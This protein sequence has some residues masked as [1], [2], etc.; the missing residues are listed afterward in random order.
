MTISIGRVFQE[1]KATHLLTH[2]LESAEEIFQRPDLLVNFIDNH[3]GARFLTKADRASF[4]QA[5]LFIMTIP[6]VP[7][8][9]YGTEQELLGMR[10][11]MFK[12]GVGSSNKDHFDTTRQSFRFVQDL[13]NLRKENAVLRRGKIDILKDSKVGPGIFIYKL[14]SEGEEILVLMN[15]ANV[16]ML[17]DNVPTGFSAGT[18]LKALFSLKEDLQSIQVNT[19]GAI[20]LVLPA[21]AGLVLARDGIGMTPKPKAASIQ[22]TSAGGILERGLTE[23][24][25]EGAATDLENIQIVVDGNLTHAV[26]AEVDAMGHWSGTISLK[27]K[28]NGAHQISAFARADDQLNYITDQMMIEINHLQK[29]LVNYSDA[30]GD[31][32]GPNGTYQYPTHA[33]YGQ[34]MDI[35]KVEIYAIGANLQVEMTMHEISQI[36]IPPNG[37]DHLLVNIFIDLPELEGRQMLPRLNASMPGE[38]DWDFLISA[39]GFGNAMFS[40]LG[41]TK[42]DMGEKVGPTA[43]ISVDK[44]ENTIRFLISAQSMGWIED[45]TGVKLYITTW[46]GGPGNPRGLQEKPSTWAFSGGLS[47]DPKIMDA[48]ELIIL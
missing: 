20:N 10:Q 9:Y 27:D 5:L 38:E 17:V 23:L 42:D 4:R 34:N 18:N 46:G 8:I 19:H 43:G 13:M 11:A 47:H 16:E 48:T 21:S 41:A 40:S 3:D 26:N 33:S 25:V 29:L 30:I 22:I 1:K 37:F 28:L 44:A 39:G 12:G 2:R 6:G 45:I 32:H 31:D 36:W 35:S 7:V 14:T 24:R 15:T